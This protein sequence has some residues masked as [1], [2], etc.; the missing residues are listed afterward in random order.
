MK[1]KLKLVLSLVAAGAIGAAAG[2]LFSPHKGTVLRRNLRRKGEAIAGEVT[3]NIQDGIG[4]I[5]DAVTEKVSTAKKE[6]ASK[7]D[8]LRDS[9][10]N[11]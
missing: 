5:S 7:F 9:F 2:A 8:T 4:H 10:H 3:E 6:I 11:G 1:N